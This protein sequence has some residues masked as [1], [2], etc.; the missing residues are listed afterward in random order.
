MYLRDVV[1]GSYPRGIECVNDCE[2]SGASRPK[3][4]V[5]E[6]LEVV[7][8]RNPISENHLNGSLYPR[9]PN[10]YDC[11]PSFPMGFKPHSG[12][13][14]Q[15]QHLPHGELE[16]PPQKKTWNV[17]HKPCVRFFDIDQKS[18]VN[19]E[20]HRRSVRELSSEHQ[21]PDFRFSQSLTR[22]YA[23]SSRVEPLYPG[24]PRTTA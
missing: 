13:G 9:L 14:L 15:W 6:I 7:R 23:D 20:Y 19:A 3:P 18:V 4:I 8:L 10:R 11:P 1:F 24:S 5:R 12:V 21:S 22:A 16:S 17:L 2:V